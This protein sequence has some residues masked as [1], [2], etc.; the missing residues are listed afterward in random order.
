MVMDVRHSLTGLCFINQ[1]I[2][3][4]NSGSIIVFLRDCF[5][6]VLILQVLQ[7]Y[8]CLDNDEKYIPM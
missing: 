5:V 8:S 2:Y 1:V 7:W 3:N 6:M 4:L